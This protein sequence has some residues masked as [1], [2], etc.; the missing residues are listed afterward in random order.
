L[1]ELWRS[2]RS[3]ILLIKIPITDEVKIVAS[4]VPLAI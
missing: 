4:I 1:E 2:A 3:K